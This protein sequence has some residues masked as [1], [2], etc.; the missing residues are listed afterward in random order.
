MLGKWDTYVTNR[1]TVA[2]RGATYLFDEAGEP[3]YSYRHLLLGTHY[4][5]LATY[6]SP[7]RR[8]APQLPLTT[9]HSP[10]PTYPSPLS[11]D[12]LA[13]HYC[14]PIPT[15]SGEP[16]Y[17]YRHRGVLTYSETMP[18]PLTFLAPYI[19]EQR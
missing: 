12:H 5:R 13:S 19:G 15:P 8:A 14:I 17:S 1:E 16:L 3:L 6:H 7:L 11:I 10:P 18:R 9:C 4:L 2:L